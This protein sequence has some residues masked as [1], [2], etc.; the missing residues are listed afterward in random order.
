MG[1]KRDVVSY[2]QP[3]APK[4]TTSPLETLSPNPNFEPS[5]ASKYGYM[6]VGALMGIGTNFMTNYQN[7]R[8]FLSGETVH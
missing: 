2:P 5:L 3:D 4:L 7:R 6:A 1:T 8:P